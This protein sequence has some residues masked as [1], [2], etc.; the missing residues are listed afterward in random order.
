VQGCVEFINPVSLAGV[1]A[2]YEG[3]H[4]ERRRGT[5]TQAVDYCTKLDTRVLGPWKF[6]KLPEGQGA[7]MDIRK[8]VELIKSGA[9]DEEVIAES[10][11]V[12]VKYHSGLSKVRIAI[13]S[14]RDWLTYTV[15]IYGP[16]GT[17][18]TRFAADDSKQRFGD[19]VYW[20]S[21]PSGNGTV[22]FDGYCG[23]ESIIID[24][25]YGWIPR[26]LMQRMCDRYPFQVQT[27]G[28]FVQFL[29][30]RIYITSNRSPTFWWRKIGLGA[31]ARR[32]EGDMGEIKYMGNEKYPEQKDYD[33]AIAIEYDP[34][35]V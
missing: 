33:Y 9:T 7:R 3:A 34:V 24:E 32:L 2:L 12:F 6:G 30:K 17:G 15:A 14:R 1:R 35:A 27:K 23:Q 22:W 31:M 8:T 4:F 20:L 16:P 11:E 28:G 21:A 29:A 18:K 25:F 5:P 10:P 13:G 26:D 19:S